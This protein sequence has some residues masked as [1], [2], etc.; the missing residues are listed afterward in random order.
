MIISAKKQIPSFRGSLTTVIIT[1]MKKFIIRYWK[2]I[3]WCL[4]I[5]IFSSIPNIPKAEIIWWDFIFKKSAHIGEYAILFYLLYQAGEQK[6]NW[7]IINE[8]VASLRRSVQ[9]F[10]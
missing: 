6:G 4:V 10:E 3:I 7:T 1:S 8:C 5:F 9:N 2:V